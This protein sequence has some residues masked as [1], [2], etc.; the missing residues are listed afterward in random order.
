MAPS[1]GTHR[2]GWAVFLV[3]GGHH[4]QGAHETSEAALQALLVQL[5]AS[6]QARWLLWEISIPW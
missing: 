5:Q 3:V 2:G 1:G 6:L 4:G